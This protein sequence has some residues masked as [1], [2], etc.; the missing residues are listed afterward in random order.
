M[1]NYKM[2]ILLMT[3]GV[4]MT[5]LGCSQQEPL[6]LSSSTSNED[7]DGGPQSDTCEVSFVTNKCMVLVYENGTDYSFVPRQTNSTYAVDE[8]GNALS[9]DSTSELQVSFK[10]ICDE[11]YLLGLDS[12]EIKGTY[13]AIVN[14]PMKDETPPYDDPMLWKISG[15]KSDL[16]VT[17]TPSQDLLGM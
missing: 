8:N 4:T 2:M 14:N 7:K 15:I 17:I 12:F 5:L 3:I 13:D 10:V 11:G 9:Y 6:Y 1:K 16:V